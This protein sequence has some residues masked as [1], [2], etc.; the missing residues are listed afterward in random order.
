MVISDI[1]LCVEV[2]TPGFKRAYFKHVFLLNDDY[3]PM[4]FVVHI[5]ENFFALNR[6]KAV[7]VMLNVHTDGKGV[8]GTFSKEIAET[9]VNQVNEYS[10]KNHH[11]LMCDLEPE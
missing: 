3:T 1:Y 2:A 9:K 11:P 4:D 8:C 7:Q 5:L 6:E 10:K